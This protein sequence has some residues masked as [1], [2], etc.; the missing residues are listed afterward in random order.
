M[1]EITHAHT[2]KRKTLTLKP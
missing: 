1:I 2:H